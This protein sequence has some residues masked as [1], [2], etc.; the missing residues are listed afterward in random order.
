MR[1]GLAGF[2]GSGKTT[3]FN[4][5]TGLDVPVGYGGEIR[6]GTVRVPDP[7]LDFLSGIYSP[8]KTTYATINLRDVPG[9]HGAAHGFCHPELCRRS[10]T[11][12]LSA[13]SCGTS[14]TPR[15]KAT[16]I[17][18]ATC[19]LSTTSAFSRIW[20]SWSGVWTVPARNARTC[21]KSTPSKR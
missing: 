21:A 7:R 4:A 9:E 10:A 14:S 13:L 1:F 17:R 8:K 6:V 2:A 15:S 20:P 19:G 12:R 3:L 16:P 5:M 18:S 11:G